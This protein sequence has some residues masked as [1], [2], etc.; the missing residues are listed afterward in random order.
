VKLNS[1]HISF[2]ISALCHVAGLWVYFL[3]ATNHR[4]LATL[5]ETDKAITITFIA[6]PKEPAVQR[7]VVPAVTAPVAPPIIT[8][9]KPPA[10]I[11]ANVQTTPKPSVA[12]E[13]KPLPPSAP[14]Q[15][16]GDGSS[17]KP[18]LDA[19]TQKAVVGVKAEPNY[20]KNP[21]PPYPL[22]ARRRH[23]EGLV[24]ISVRVTA[25]GRAEKVE[26]KQSS[27][28]PLLD[29]AALNAVRDWEFIP[30]RVGNIALASEIEVPVHFKLAD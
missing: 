3:V 5:P 12:V 25:Q 29:E 27:G 21:E 30:A 4:E 10:E 17:P 8:P 22:A 2:A 1:F 9:A 16:H 15:T 28:Y 20:L 13:T 26:V 19:T 24:L 18:G 6:A 14:A 7:K 11:P 23:Q